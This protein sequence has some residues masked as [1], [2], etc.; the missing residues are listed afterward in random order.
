VRLELSLD[1]F[2]QAHTSARSK[3]LIETVRGIL[4][5]ARTRLRVAGAIRHAVA[6]AEARPRQ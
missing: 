3:R 6:V 5:V 1:R 4:S 2:A